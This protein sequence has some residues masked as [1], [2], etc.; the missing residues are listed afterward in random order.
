MD[1]IKTGRFIAFIANL[2]FKAQIL[3]LFLLLIYLFYQFLFLERIGIEEAD[4]YNFFTNNIIIFSA[5]LISCLTYFF[6]KKDS[7][8]NNY[9][10]IHLSTIFSLFLLNLLL[11]IRSLYFL[12]D[13]RIVQFE[14]KG[15]IW[16]K[17]TRDEVVSDLRLKTGEKNIYKVI[18]PGG[19]ITGNI[20]KII[21]FKKD[22]VPLSNVSNSTIIH[23]NE[24]GIW[25][26]YKSDKFGFNNP[27]NL[28]KKE[29]K[30]NLLLLGDSFTEGMCV[31]TKND[32][33]AKLRNLNYN[34]LN[35]GKAGGGVLF[36]KARLREYKHA[37]NFKPDYVIFLFF[38]FND[39]TD[40][41][42]EYNHP[43]FQKYLNDKQF[44]QDLK[45]KQDKI[46]IFWKRFFALAS[47]ADFRKKY[48]A[49]TKYGQYYERTYDP[50]TKSLNYKFHLKN[51]LLLT[52]IR[53]FI[54][55]NLIAQ[56]TNRKSNEKKNQ[57]DILKKV[58]TS[59]KAEVNEIDSK[60]KLILVYLPSHHEIINKKL[61]LRKEIINLTNELNIDNIN[62][63]ESFIKMNINDLFDY[64]LSGHYSSEG[65]G[66]LARI[67]N[68]HLLEKY[69]N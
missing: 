14:K 13:N 15:V 6:I 51:I 54:H 60:T 21:G 27:E 63:Y 9:F 49:L 59:F 58:F 64:G 47:K 61:Y 43:F 4:K 66:H 52:N 33:G 67:I 56:I 50:P 38:S 1:N 39:V 24:S 8:K 46:D 3:F 2:Y 55:D 5:L 32:I 20:A 22:I 10:L 19:F 69:G 36:A 26:S 37:Y 53:A 42:R 18:D 45:N 25:R 23:C 30:F 12:P 28:I 44:S 17:R 31:D 57:L 65:Y 34:V 29:S 40:T 16:D 11:E 62:I 35:L 48:P 41:Q 7:I 68:Q